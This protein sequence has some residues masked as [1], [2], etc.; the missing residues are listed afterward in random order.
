MA[1]LKKGSGYST[2]NG[3]S[4][5]LKKPS[6]GPR[7]YQTSN[8]RKNQFRKIYVLRISESSSTCLITLNAKVSLRASIMICYA[9]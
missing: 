6:S 7:G 4:T 2:D 8:F 5:S 9:S 1:I 3:V